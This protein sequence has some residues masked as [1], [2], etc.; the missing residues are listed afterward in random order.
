MD[1]RTIIN[2]YQDYGPAELIREW[3]AIQNGLDR[4][5][6]SVSNTLKKREEIASRIEFSNVIS[7]LEKSAVAITLIEEVAQG[8]LKERR[9]YKICGC[10]TGLDKGGVFIYGTAI[11]DA[12]LSITTAAVL[13]NNTNK[14]EKDEKDVNLWIPF[15]ITSVSLL[16]AIAKDYGW[17]KLQEYQGDISRLADLVNKNSSGY[18]KGLIRSFQ[19]MDRV[20]RKL[21]SDQSASETELERELKVIGSGSSHQKLPLDIFIG[22]ID[23]VNKAQPGSKLRAAAQLIIEK[24]KKSN[25]SENQDSTRSIK[26]PRATLQ[27]QRRGNEEKPR[28]TV[29][30]KFAETTCC[31]WKVDTKT[32]LEKAKDIRVHINQ[33][34]NSLDNEDAKKQEDFSVLIE[35][36]LTS[37]KELEEEVLYPVRTFLEEEADWMG[38]PCS[39]IKSRFRSG[40]HYLAN[41]V[42]LVVLGVDGYKESNGNSESSD[43]EVVAT[44]M[45]IASLILGKWNDWMY[46]SLVEK[47]IRRGEMERIQRHAEISIKRCDGLIPFYQLLQDLI[48]KESVITFEEVEKTIEQAAMMPTRYHGQAAKFTKKIIKEKEITRSDFEKETVLQKRIQQIKADTKTSVENGKKEPHVVFSSDSDDEAQRNSRVNSEIWDFNVERIQTATQVE[49]ARSNSTPAGLSFH[50]RQSPN[51]SQEI[52][53][54]FMPSTFSHPATTAKAMKEHKIKESITHKRIKEIKNE[55]RPIRK[56]SVENG[57]K[58]SQV[59]FSCDSDDETATEN[60]EIWDLKIKSIQIGEK[61]EIAR[62]TSAIS[63]SGSD[64]R[65]RAILS[66]QTQT[67]DV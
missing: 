27:Y 47:K 17:G 11:I 15:G 25:D 41:L 51:L 38:R 22:S 58:K 24:N 44:V 12:I 2:P 62:S 32:V 50:V 8:I 54:T 43:F 29:I 49:M 16:V 48:K 3:T 35:L 6:D 53:A 9:S 28:R 36:L 57:E 42:T 56:R 52:E 26:E 40:I 30:D 21:E 59:L 67:T 46:K 31:D 63:A 18:I 5:V 23:K 45:V 37:K 1:A 19:A 7:S 60:S 61:I 55:E 4:I 65:D 64:F 10:N 33:T 39:Q 20:N 14:D 66:Q 34:I 13:I